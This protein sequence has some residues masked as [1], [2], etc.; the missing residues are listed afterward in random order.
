MRVWAAA[1]LAMLAGLLP[2]AA[3]AHP[4]A[5]IDLTVHVLFDDKGRVAA[6]QEEWLFDEY[7]TAYALEALGKSVDDKLSAAD[8]QQMVNQT[9]DSLQEWKYFTR[10]Y[11]G[12]AEIAGAKVESAAGHMEKGRWVLR[13]TLPLAKPLAPGEK[14]FTYS[15]F[16]PSYYIEMLHKDAKGAIVLDNAPQGCNARKTKPEPDF[17]ALSLAAAADMARPDDQATLGALFAEKVTVTCK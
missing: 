3:F 6:L 16:D 13:F 8:F 2:G 15:I 9:M 5:W 12:D 10:L 14:G 4:H 11:A 1:L 17:E 7:Y